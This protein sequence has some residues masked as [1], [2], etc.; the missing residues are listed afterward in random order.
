MKWSASFCMLQVAIML[1]GGCVESRIPRQVRDRASDRVE[2]EDYTDR[3]QAWA[4]SVTRSMTLEQKAGMVLLPA[5]FTRSD[6]VTMAQL[7]AYA[8]SLHVGGIILLKGDTA[9]AKAIRARLNERGRR[10]MFVAVDAEWGLGMRFSD[11]PKYPVNG[12]L[13]IEIREEDMFDYGEDVARQCR[14]LGINMVLGPVADVLPESGRSYIGKRSFG[15]DARRVAEL[16]ASYAQGLESGGVMS[17][18]KHFPGQGSLQGDTHKMLPTLPS[19]L[20]RLDS[21]DLHPFRTYVSRG[22]SGVMVGHVYVPSI[23]TVPRSAALSPVVMHDLLREDLGFRGLVI[24]DALNMGGAQGGSAVEAVMAGA[25][26]VIAPS[27]TAA[28]I[29]EIVAAVRGGVMRESVLDDRCRR[30]LFYKYRFSL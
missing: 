24:T 26:M 1:L 16:A 5:L 14:R 29:S 20:H 18:V 27:R 10:D 13:P 25:D 17:V 8:D 15:S 7:D 28:S 19:S 12:N 6:S 4:D 30:I 2:V 9:S 11:A 3:A 23:D 22:L 21:V